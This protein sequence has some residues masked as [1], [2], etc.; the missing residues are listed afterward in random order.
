[1]EHPKGECDQS[2]K[3]CV[4]MAGLVQWFLR[5]PHVHTTTFLQG[6]LGQCAPKPTT[7][8]LGRIN[9]FALKVFSHYDTSWRPQGY[10][11]GK[12]QNGW[13]TAKAKIYPV[14]LSRIIAECHLEHADQI[15]Q[16]GHDEIPD[17]LKAAID[18]LSKVHDPDEVAAFQQMASDFHSGINDP[19]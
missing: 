2:P 13:R 9:N 14:L 4:W 6:P 17:D 3:W 8:L 16:E 12:D 11:G 7:L 19:F 18:V 5:A 1:M 10:L 15:Q